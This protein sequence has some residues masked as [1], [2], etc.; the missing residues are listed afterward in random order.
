MSAQTPDRSTIESRFREVFTY[1]GFIAAYARRRGARDPDGIA[2]EAMAI[3]WRRLADVPVDDARPWLIVTARNL[4]MAERRRE[5]ATRR[6]GLDGV[7]VAAPPQPL[8]PELDLDPDLAAGLR[9]LSES[10]REA[11]LLVAWEDLTPALAAASL[12]ITPAAFRVRLH[13]ARRRLSDLLTER[14]PATGLPGSETN[15]RQT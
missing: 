9:A 11:L 8:A 3:A 7:D 12:G 13:R 5:P 1:L 4:M 10:D 6:H 15:W 14:V 2:A